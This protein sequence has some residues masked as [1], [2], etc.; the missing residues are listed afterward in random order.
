MKVRIAK[1]R[2]EASHRAQL[3]LVMALLGTFIL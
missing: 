3:D 2:K 1:Q